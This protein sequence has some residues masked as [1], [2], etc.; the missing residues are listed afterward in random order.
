M[1]P[2]PVACFCNNYSW[3]NRCIEGTDSSSKM[4]K[5]I[6]S[7]INFIN[8]DF[9]WGGTYEQTK[10]SLLLL[11]IF[12]NRETLLTTLIKHRQAQ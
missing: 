8:N 11:K 2:I 6:D 3:W 10:H 5:E 7:A 4:C 12:T 1:H 9:I